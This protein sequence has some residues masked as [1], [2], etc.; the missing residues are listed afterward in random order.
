MRKSQRLESEKMMDRYISERLII[1]TL[2]DW[3]ITS[4]FRHIGIADKMND[5]LHIE[6][7]NLIRNLP[8]IYA[9]D[10]KQ[11]K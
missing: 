8:G 7:P 10:L 1:K 2:L 5:V 11:V 6:I 4:S 3:E 9:K